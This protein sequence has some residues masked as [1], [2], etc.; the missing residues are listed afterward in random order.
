MHTRIGKRFIDVPYHPAYPASRNDRF[1]V[2][3]EKGVLINAVAVR[4][5]RNVGDGY[6][7]VG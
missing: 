6:L 7:R 5:E 1:A 3:P 4:A 2:Y